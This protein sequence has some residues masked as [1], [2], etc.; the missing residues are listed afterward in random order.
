MDHECGVT[1][2]IKRG[3]TADAAVVSEPSA[4]PAPLAVVPVSPGLLVVL[5]HRARQGD[6]RV[7][8]RRTLSAPAAWA[9]R[10]ASTRSTRASTCSRRCASSRTS[11]A[12]RKRHP[13]FPPGHFTIH[14]G[15]V[16]GGPKGVLVPFS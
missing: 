9:R 3:Y 14:P 7:D 5:G 16:T 15:V 4:P 8:A 1:A 6:A 12:R 13:L 2:T 11:G 10:S